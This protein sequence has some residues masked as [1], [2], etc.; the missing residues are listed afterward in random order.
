MRDLLGRCLSQSS[1][2]HWRVEEESEGPWIWVATDQAEIPEQGWKLH[3]SATV[4]SA[5]TVL[6]TA[7][8][9]LVGSGANFKIARSLAQLQSLNEGRLGFSQVGKFI[10]VYPCNSAHAVRLAS[11]LDERLQGIPH[12]DI[13]SDKPLKPRSVVH[14]RYGSFG[15]RCVRTPIGQLLSAVQKPDGVLVPDRRTVP[16]RQPEWLEDPFIA[17]GTAAPLPAPSR[18]L[19]GRYLIVH[20]VDESARG[21]V[22]LGADVISGRRCVLK[23]AARDAQ[24]DDTGRGAADRLRHEA[25]LLRRFAGTLPVPTVFDLIDD[26]EDV[27]L[28]MEDVEGEILSDYVQ[29]RAAE[30]RPLSMAEVAAYGLE[31]ASLLG[32]IHEQAV[33]YRDLKSDN[34]VVGVDRRLWLVDFEISCDLNSP[35]TPDGRGT[36]G[37]MSPQAA[38]GEAATVLDDVYGLGALLYFL[39]TAAEP[40]WAPADDELTRRPIT[41]LNPGISPSLAS[42]INRCLAPRAESRF[43]TMT[44]VAEALARI[45]VP[46]D[47]KAAPTEE[48]S[49]AE[50]EANAPARALALAR[51][52]GDSLCD[53]ARRDHS[54]IFWTSA[55]EEEGASEQRYLAGG[56]A[57]VLLAI[58]ELVGEFGEVRHQEAL[59]EGIEWLRASR[60]VGDILPGL[61]I[62][63]LGVAAAL[64]RAGQV[65]SR[66]DLIDHAATIMRTIAALPYTS[67]DI[68]HGTAGRLRF[69]LLLWQETRDPEHLAHAVEAGEFL[70]TQC[71]RVGNGLARWTIPPGFEDLSG[72]AYLGYAHGAAGIG[73]ALLDLFLATG[74]ERFLEASQSAARWLLT[75]ATRRSDGGLNWP[76][77]DAPADPP[78]GAFWCHGAAGIG[79]FFLNLA[80]AEVFPDAF[81]TA[82]QA[83]RTVAASSRRVGPTQCHGIAGNIEFLLD[84]HQMSCD[85]GFLNDALPLARILE[86]FSRERDG[87]L[88]WL[89][90]SPRLITPDYMVGYAGIA[91]CL[92]R[93]GN[94]DDRPYQLSLRGFRWPSRSSSSWAAGTMNVASR[95]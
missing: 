10:T 1:A 52:L 2:Q 48:R 68:F 4:V 69:N 53:S 77:L 36:E 86:A 8:P 81:D 19:A 13:P 57:G 67:P 37:Y 59:T 72:D 80:A 85:G 18:F 54:G 92:L 71:E 21:S 20:T 34:L 29:R 25:G 93:L 43:P 32:A 73:D 41:L 65:L 66:C 9:V 23:R 56:S 83:A 50:S 82:R 60:P 14:Y 70:L 88:V 58:A 30:G 35:A 42:I 44:A 87:R 3:L 55:Y 51:R 38:E 75:K 28:V 61:Y 49:R 39:A 31:L 95:H 46:A 76:T 79:R 22:H 84:M 45:Q 33:V 7:L 64:V 62:G 27:C 91:I 17:S 5:N 15:Q 6:C 26:G 24:V 90:D 74:D 89:S 78:A 94:P 16:Y 11:A 40:S 12:P 47:F 63:E